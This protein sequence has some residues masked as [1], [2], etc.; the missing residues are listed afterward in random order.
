VGL[1]ELRIEVAGGTD[2]QVR[3]RYLKESEAHRLRNALLAAAAGVEYEQ[4]EEAPEAP[5]REVLQ[6]PPGR[7]VAGTAL[8]GTVLVLL[9]GGT[10]MVVALAVAALLPGVSSRM[11]LAPIAAIGP[12]AA[13]AVVVTVANSFARS[14]AFRLA[15]SP[16]GLRV[17]AGLTE[18]RSA[19]VPPGRVQAVLVSQSWLWRRF[20]WWHVKVNIAGYAQQQDGQGSSS[21]VL[22]PVGTRADVRALLAL[23]VPGGTDGASAGVDPALL[24]AG[25]SG[26]GSARGFVVVPRGARWLDPFAWRRTGYAVADR[27]LLARTGVLNRQLVVVPHERTQSVGVYQGPL[28]RRLGLVSVRLHSTPGPVNPLVP[29]LSEA[30]GARLVSEQGSRARAAR[31][32]S[33]PERWMQRPSAARVGLGAVDQPVDVDQGDRGPGDLGGGEERVEVD[34]L[35][36]DGRP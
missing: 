22:L 9:L 21:A 11:V 6:V 7:L 8:T 13:I 16:D 27:V 17:R 24:E 28:Q 10:G 5:E 3:L 23:V 2:S 19:T 4:G 35:R 30:E 1:A 20:D 33:G 34:G 14:F 25:L 26:A 32:A 31:A 15:E 18:T 36:G 29:H 12:G